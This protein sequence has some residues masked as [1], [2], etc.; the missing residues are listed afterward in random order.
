MKKH[1][2]KSTNTKIYLPSLKK[3][4]DIATKLGVDRIVALEVILDKA[5]KTYLN[6]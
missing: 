1:R 2:P 3:L 5:S 4:Q 6:K